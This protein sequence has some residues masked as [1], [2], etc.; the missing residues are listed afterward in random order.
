MSHQR[1]SRVTV[2]FLILL[3]AF[4]GSVPLLA[5][6]TGEAQGGNK[7][8]LVYTRYVDAGDL[9]G[10][11]SVLPLEVVIKPELGVIML[12]GSADLIDTAKKVVDALDV[13]PS[14]SPNIELRG[15]II[16]VSKDKSARKGV[17]D[18]IAG[19]VDELAEIFGY[20]GFEVLDTMFLRT[21][22]GSG[23]QVGGTLELESGRRATYNMGFNYSKILGFDRARKEEK[24][25]TV[26][27]DG[28]ILRQKPSTPPALE[29]DV[30]V[31][32]GQT[33]VIGK[34]RLDGVPEDLILVIKANVIG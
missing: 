6:D 25:H 5:Q 21:R 9:Q 34:A 7:T 20:T 2:F 1:F 17:V 26:R 32:E 11:L 14:P 33:A 12:H 29:T 13:P 3:G 16:A 28:L 18:E 4:C 22:H 10:V 15:Y 30:E 27:F 31:R 19:V 24:E 8:V 23:G